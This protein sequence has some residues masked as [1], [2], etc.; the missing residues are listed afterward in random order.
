MGC[1]MA[2]APASLPC[3]M[4]VEA[5]ATSELLYIQP[6]LE[7]GHGLRDGAGIQAANI[8]DRAHSIV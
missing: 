7:A 3:K 1:A 8:C 4:R 6:H 2:Q 5:H